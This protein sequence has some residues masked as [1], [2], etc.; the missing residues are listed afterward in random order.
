MAKWY[1]ED[2]INKDFTSISPWGGG[3]DA[4]ASEECGAYEFSMYSLKPAH[5]AMIPGDTDSFDAVP[6]PAK[7]ADRRQGDLHFR[8]YNFITGDAPM[9]E[10]DTFVAEIEAMDIQT[11]L[12]AQQAALDRYNA[13]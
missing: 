3:A 7:T 11:A 6:Y 2:L 12:D 1:A 5:D 9:S 8:R 13:R 4:Y 10:W